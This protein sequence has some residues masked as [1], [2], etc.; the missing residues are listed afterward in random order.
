MMRSWRDQAVIIDLTWR[1]YEEE[2]VTFPRTIRKS[3][4][5]FDVLEVRRMS[6]SVSLGFPDL[7]SCLFLPVMVSGRVYDLGVINSNQES[8][9]RIPI[10]S[11]ICADL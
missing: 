6:T 4:C 10:S 7:S 5:R 11:W 8:L 9:Y 2:R 1:A 3:I